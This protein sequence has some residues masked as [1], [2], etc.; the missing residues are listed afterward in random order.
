MP[1]GCASSHSRVSRCPSAISRDRAATAKSRSSGTMAPE[2]QELTRADDSTQ[3]L[4]RSRHLAPLGAFCRPALQVH[5]EPGRWNVQMITLHCT[6]GERFQADDAHAGKRIRCRCG[7]L[8]RIPGVPV[9]VSAQYHA[10]TSLGASTDPTSAPSPGARS[11][12]R[13]AWVTVGAAVSLVF[14]VF[15]VSVS[16]GGREGVPTQRT[17]PTI[18]SPAASSPPAVTALQPQP[19]PADSVIQPR[20]STELGADHRGGLGRLSVSNGSQFD[21]VAVL[22]GAANDVP[23][24]AIYIRRDELG[25]ITQL[26][27]G[28][29]RLRFQFG[30]SWHVS[31]YF[32]QVVGTSEFDD[33]FDFDEVEDSD[34]VEYKTFEVTLHPVPQGTATTRSIPNTA[35]Q[36]LPE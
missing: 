30:S 17:T 22:L 4:R 18:P 20:S 35:F 15:L 24:R 11:S 9:Q 1:G 26:P 8:V 21:A 19:C 34:G 16:R 33:Q 32:C 2:T 7:L 25:V 31:R 23:L 3:L 12:R 10:H 5:H 28:R 27:P 6:C 13:G 29:Y 14:L 36:L